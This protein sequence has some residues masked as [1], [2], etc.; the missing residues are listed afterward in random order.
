[1]S[2][3]QIKAVHQRDL[4]SLLKSLKVY[5]DVVNQSRHCFF[6][7]KT[8]DEF[9]ISAVFP[10]ESSVCFCCESP[11]CC[12]CLLDMSKEEDIDG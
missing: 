10:H 6:C 9:T 5:D 7:R 8:V 2:N 12:S 4:R 11:L 3:S 1:M